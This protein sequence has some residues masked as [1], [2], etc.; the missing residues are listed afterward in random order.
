MGKNKILKSP[1]FVRFTVNKCDYC[2]QT[3]VNNFTFDLNSPY[4]KV[5]SKFFCCEEC[6]RMYQFQKYK[7]IL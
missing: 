4:K 2:H 6:L 1:T 7:D 3:I 5:F